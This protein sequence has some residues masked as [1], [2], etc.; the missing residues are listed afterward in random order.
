MS[1]LPQTTD[2]WVSANVETNLNGSESTSISLLITFTCGVRE[3]VVKYV[4]NLNSNVEKVTI[5]TRKL[6]NTDL[7]I[8]S[9]IRVSS[10][11]SSSQTA[12]N[13]SICRGPELVE[14][15]DSPRSS[16]I[17]HKAAI[18]F[19]YPLQSGFFVCSASLSTSLS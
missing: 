14:I 16:D 19:R 13:L 2:V 4:I 8:R 7:R 6:Q 9:E 12:T 10:E 11:L 18:A 1:P 15:H 17:Q 5:H 3:T